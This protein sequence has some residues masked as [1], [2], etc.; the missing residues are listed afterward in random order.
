M[1]TAQLQRALQWHRDTSSIFKG[2]FPANKLPTI[3]KNKTLAIIANTDPSHRPGQHWVA[4]FFK[5]EHVY[6]FDSYGQKPQ[7]AEFHK[8]MMCRKY[9][10]FFGRRIQGSG[11]ECGFY[12]LYFIL[13]MVQGKSFDIFG[14]DLN[15]NDRCVRNIV[16]KH[17]EIF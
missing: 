10:H 13:S 16:Q 7:K 1:K 12:C 4:F 14:D 15:A 17:F 5:R 6:F 9:K 8:L 11:K 2:V 3:P